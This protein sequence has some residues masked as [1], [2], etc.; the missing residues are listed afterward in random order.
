MSVV[1]IDVS[2]DVLDIAISG[3]SR[4]ETVPHTDLSIRAL[5]RRLKRLKAE[6]IVLEATGGL[7][8]RLVDALGEARLPGVTVNPLRVRR[9]AQAWGI[10]AKTDGID[11]SV[12]V[13]YGEKVEPEVRPLPSREVRERLR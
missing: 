5:V 8:R 11:A 7:E 9:F 6:R 12:L 10:L 2:K 3:G 1:G 13:L 4:V